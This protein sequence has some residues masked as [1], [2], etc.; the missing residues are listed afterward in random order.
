MVSDI[1]EDKRSY[2]Q[3]LIEPLER[4]NTS[5]NQH[6]FGQYPAWFFL[7]CLWGIVSQLAMIG[8]TVLVMKYEV[9]LNVWLGRFI[10]TVFSIIN[11]GVPFFIWSLLYQI[12]IIAVMKD[13][14]YYLNN[15]LD[16]FDQ[17]SRMFVIFFLLGSMVSDKIYCKMKCYSSIIFVRIS[18]NKKHLS[19][20]VLKLGMDIVVR[21]P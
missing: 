5:S 18:S 2:D 15:V 20:L 16:A 12:P 9:G 7:G 4:A 19:L 10:V 3:I 14:T 21:I 1:G 8:F 17:L 11:I 6:R 13:E